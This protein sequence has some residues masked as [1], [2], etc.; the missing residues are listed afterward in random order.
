MWSLTSPRAERISGPEKFS[1]VSQKR[2]LQQYR[3]FSDMAWML[4][5]VR[6]SGQSGSHLEARRRQVLTEKQKFDGRSERRF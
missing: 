1:F 3:H 2:L 4:R 5:D 6:S